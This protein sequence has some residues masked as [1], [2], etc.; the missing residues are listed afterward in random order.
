MEH[1]LSSYSITV[2]QTSVVK[3]VGIGFMCLLKGLAIAAGTTQSREMNHP[4]ITVLSV[5]SNRLKTDGADMFL[6]H[7]FPLSAP[8][9]ALKSTL[10][11]GLAW[12]FGEIINRHQ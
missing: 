2:L 12:S 11:R 8:N 5:I 1:P 7:V 10:T 9:K 6:S 4:A 3:W